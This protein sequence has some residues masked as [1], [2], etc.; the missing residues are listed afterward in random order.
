MFWIQRVRLAALLLV[1]GVKTVVAQTPAEDPAAEQPGRGVSPPPDTQ[2][3]TAANASELTNETART[4]NTFTHTGYVEA[5]YSW[6]FNDPSNGI[7]NYRGFDNRHNSF[8]L[9][10]VVLDTRWDYEDIVG[11]AALQIGHTPSTYYLAEPSSGGARGANATDSELWKY[12]QQAYVGYRFDVGRGL[13]ATAGLFL[14]PIGPEGMAVKDNWNWS[15]SNLFFGCPFYHTGARLTYPFTNEWAATFAVYNG[16]NSVTDN[17]EEK[18]LSGQLTYTVQDKIAWSFL[19]FSGVE[20]AK[21]APEGNAWR[22]LLDTYVTWYATDK[23]SLLAHFDTGLEPNNV[24]TSSWIAGAL[25]AR[26]HVLEQLYIA[27]RGD[28]F[29]EN[30]PSDSTGSASA[31]FWP[32]SWVAS[33]TA[34]LDYRPHERVSLRLE[35]RHDHAEGDMYFGGLVMGDGA[36]VP[37]APNRNSQ[38][39]L[40]LGAITWF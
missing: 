28:M 40:T 31:I 9:S 18:S 12:V 27:A 21:G 32:V 10:N 34:T 3:L 30:V 25:Y 39:T 8:T 16:W 26:L 19:Y 7:T 5:L 2:R 37:Y 24:G 17:N 36:T 20:R 33:G 22:H 35:Y 11:R 38:D 15:R 13:L 4:E 23:L 6:N 1:C 29:Y 14:S